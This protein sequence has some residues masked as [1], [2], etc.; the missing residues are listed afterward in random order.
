[1][2]DFLLDTGTLWL[3]VI[4]L[5]LAIASTGWFPDM[6]KGMGWIYHLLFYALVGVGIAASQSR[7]GKIK[8]IA[9]KLIIVACIVI[10]AHET[11]RSMFGCDQVCQLQKQQEAEARAR[12]ETQRQIAVETV[13]YPRCNRQ[14]VAYRFDV[15]EPPS[16][17]NEAGT[18]APDVWHDGH[19]LWIRQAGNSKA[20][21]HC[22]GAMPP[23]V[24]S[25][26]SAD[27][28]FDGFV[29]LSPPQFTTLVRIIH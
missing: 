11:W 20:T 23:D 16:P 5:D 18:C 1:M 13:R 21:K 27:T 14:K 17:F 2:R 12:I 3:G 10:G 15:T 25:A 28:A 19:C 26:W 24:E 29:R 22:G 4:I 8:D 7:R 6:Y 9:F